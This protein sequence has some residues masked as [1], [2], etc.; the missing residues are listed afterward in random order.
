[1][2]AALQRNSDVEQI[3]WWQEV[4]VE[5]M[6]PRIMT[7]KAEMMLLFARFPVLSTDA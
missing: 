7:E 6:V 2:R 3:S 5:R 4:V 1:M